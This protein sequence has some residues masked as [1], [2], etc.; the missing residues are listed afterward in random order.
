M[1]NA[2]GGVLIECDP[3]IKQFILFLNKKHGN[4]I[5]LFDLDETHIFVEENQT[6]LIQQELDKLIEE[7]AY[8]CNQQK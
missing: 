5:V 6:E 3:A 4:R 8:T 7:N 2:I 1:V